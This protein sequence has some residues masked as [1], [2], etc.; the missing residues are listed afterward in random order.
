MADEKSD[1]S[2][3]P[4]ELKCNVDTHDT[5]EA[6]QYGG[7]F[8]N[9]AFEPCMLEGEGH[10][11]SLP[12]TSGDHQEY[13]THNQYCEAIIG[14]KGKVIQKK[15]TTIQINETI[16]EKTD[17][18]I[19]YNE[20]INNDLRDTVVYGNSSV[21]DILLKDRI[22]PISHIDHSPFYGK[23]IANNVPFPTDNKEIE[24]AD[25]NCENIAAQPIIVK[26][27]NL[28]NVDNST[29][30]DHMDQKLQQIPPSPQQQSQ[31]HEQHGLEESV[32]LGEVRDIILVDAATPNDL[33]ENSAAQNSHNDS[34]AGD[35]KVAEQHIGLNGEKKFSSDNQVS[36][37]MT[38]QGEL[39]GTTTTPPVL[40]S[41]M[42]SGI[43]V[44]TKL[45]SLPQP[46]VF[47]LS[48]PKKT[49]T[50]PVDQ[51]GIRDG[52]SPV[53]L[54]MVSNHTL[55]CFTITTTFL[56]HSLN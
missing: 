15:D 31:Q 5:V 12:I 7:S 30:N 24:E 16:V 49:T 26:S 21:K 6:S 44:T 17:N 13:S 40:Q 28:N 22:S 42:P 34:H 43:E 54:Q 32:V 3:K 48:T 45:P 38:K 35:T 55:L 39:M 29:Q 19:C 9:E 1:D 36:V 52:S 14:N 33:E 25:G 37:A 56:C 27:Q 53:V 4:Y 8:V 2:P 50:D 41:N 10:S 18:A 23:M 11:S 46:P 51:L 47:S 20:N